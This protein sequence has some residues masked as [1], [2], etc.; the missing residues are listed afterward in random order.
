MLIE[1]PLMQ[2]AAFVSN[3]YK[4]PHLHTFLLYL[5]P[6]AMRR[7]LLMVHMRCFSNVPLELIVESK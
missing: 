7:G 4:C 1:R 6:G 5:L 2:L 3:L